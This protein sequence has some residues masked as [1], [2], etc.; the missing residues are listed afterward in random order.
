M[1]QSNQQRQSKARS[2][3]RKQIPKTPHAP[4]SIH[5]VLF[6]YSSVI[7]SS[8]PLLH[9]G[10]TVGVKKT[11]S[12]PPV[13]I[14]CTAPD[15]DCG[16]RPD[17]L[18]LPLEPWTGSREGYRCIQHPFA[19]TQIFIDPDVDIFVFGEA[20]LLEARSRSHRWGLLANMFFLLEL[21]GRCGVV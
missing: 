16:I 18:S 17:S 11:A 10:T 15:R 19:H 7:C 3:P 14:S 9:S 13:Y 8:F 5:I 2:L 20:L 6:G 12:H 1:S 21:K 4:S